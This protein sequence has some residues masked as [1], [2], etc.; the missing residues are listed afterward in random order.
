[1]Y[2]SLASRHS[3]RAR[4]GAARVRALTL[5]ELLVVVGVI[6]LLIAITL[7]PLQ[8]ARRQAQQT[9]CAAQLQL[10]GFSLEHARYDYK[11]YPLWDDGGVPIRYTWIDLLVQRGYLETAGSAETRPPEGGA[12]S[13]DL[14][15]SPQDGVR[16]GYCPADQLPDPLN[17]ARHSNLIYPLDRSRNGIDYSYGIGV[18]LSAGGWAWRP[19]A[20][21]LS[22]NR[23]RRFRDAERDTSGRVLVADAN[24]S[25]VYNL[26]G[27]AVRSSIWNDPTQY[28]N[29]VSWG[30]HG[31]AQGS[32]PSANVLFQDGH[33]STNAYDLGRSYAV[34]TARTFVWYPGEPVTV[35]PEDQ[36][37]GFW[38]PNVPPPSALDSPPGDV[39]P[40]E[41]LPAWY[42]L[43]RGWSRI[44]HK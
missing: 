13:G 18:P 31:Y 8:L 35:N 7:P 41:L 6:A 1:M 28:D 4:R 38:Y 33:V 21:G 24:S 32:R 17:E 37:D 44:T 40:N 25:A 9:H 12:S 27:N 30:R 39:F 29:T 14:K 16:I 43:N 19:N 20:S 26:S 11:F 3:S 36:Y 23:S 5:A 34:N 22:D 10:L 2:R 15:R 42:T